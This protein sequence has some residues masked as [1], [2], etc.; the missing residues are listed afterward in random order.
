MYKPLLFLEIKH[1]LKLNN[2][3]LFILQK[4][5]SRR[6]ANEA[7]I[8]FIIRVLTFFSHTKINLKM[9]NFL[10]AQFLPKQYHDL[11]TRTLLELE[12]C[13][14]EKK[15]PS[16]S[17]C[18]RSDIKMIENII[19]AKCEN[20]FIRLP[21]IDSITFE[22]EQNETNSEIESFAEKT[23]FFVCS[24]PLRSENDSHSKNATRIYVPESESEESF[25]SSIATDT[26]FAA[27]NSQMP[28]PSPNTSSINARFFSPASPTSSSQ[29]RE[30]FLGPHRY[31]DTP[32]QAIADFYEVW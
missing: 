28:I 11:S 24:T 6:G 10:F 7:N 23:S 21:P 30:L 29:E 27:D 14:E 25:E 22:P 13:V 31:V 20:R 16:G 12:K 15:L 3:H 1:G 4:A 26:S 9:K 17:R 2:Y 8:L 18:L 32:A 19:G 5:E